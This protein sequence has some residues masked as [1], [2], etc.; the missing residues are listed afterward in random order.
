[1]H[2]VSV[3]LAVML[4]LALNIISEGEKR[5]N[6]RLVRENEFN[7]LCRFVEQELGA[8]VKRKAVTLKFLKPAFKQKAKGSFQGLRANLINNK[9]TFSNVETVEE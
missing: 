5:R 3:L 4:E 1:M 6:L 8:V 2:Y 7:R 9:I